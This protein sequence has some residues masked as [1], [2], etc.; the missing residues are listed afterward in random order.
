MSAFRAMGQI[1][2]GARGK[3]MSVKKTMLPAV[4]LLF[5][6]AA[7]KSQ[8]TASPATRSPATA[9]N[10]N[11]TAVKLRPE[12][13]A[14][15]SSPVQTPASAQ[16][17]APPAQAQSSATPAATQ[18]PAAKGGQDQTTTLSVAVKVVNVPATVRDKH[19]KIIRDLTKDDFVLEEDGR[20]QTVRYFA[21]ETDLPLT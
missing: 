12:T 1:R 4:C 7:L 3:S 18:E 14:S 8:Q 10:S 17:S 15:L 9:P 20:P 6:C 5:L 13:V 16:S 21:H 11:A 2:R 19:G